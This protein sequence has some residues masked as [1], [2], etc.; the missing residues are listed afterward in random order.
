MSAMPDDYYVTG[1]GLSQYVHGAE[2]LGLPARDVLR[3]SGLDP[4]QALLPNKRIPQRL[5]ENFILQLALYSG[6]ELLGFHIGHQVMPAIYG[7]LP[8]LAFSA[9]NGREALQLALRYQSLAG[10][11]VEAFSAR[12]TDGSMVFT[13]AMVHQNPVM[14]RHVTDNVFA[15]LAHMLRFITGTR[16]LGVQQVAVEYAAP[17]ADVRKR[18]EQLYGCPVRYS[19][20]SNHIELGPA[21]LNAPLNVHDPDQLRLAEELARKQLANQQQTFDWVTQVRQ[22]VRDLMVARSP[23]RELVAERLG[24]SVRTLDRRLADVGMTWQKLVDALRAQ[25]A[26]E[27]LADPALSIQTIATRL[28]FADVRAFQRRFRVWT[29]TTPSEYRGRLSPPSP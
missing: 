19:A 22:Q 2:R 4:A 5:Y 15:L 18:M 3:A 7:A 27:C 8:A 16:Q 17:S 26:V 10:G 12:E 6:D 9:A 13:W 28:G 21:L 11:T 20:S 14:R 1:L 23:R 25:Q 24:V 29:G